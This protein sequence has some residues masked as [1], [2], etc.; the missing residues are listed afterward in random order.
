MKSLII[1]PARK[2]SKRIKNKNLIQILK[3]PLIYWT[4]RYAK[5]LDKKNFDI[6]VTSNCQKIKKICKQEKIFFIDRPKRLSGDLISMHDVIFHTLNTCKKKYKYVILLQ[7]TSP[8]RKSN[9]VNKSIK[10]L[11][12]KDNFDSLIHLA[13]NQSYTGKVIKNKWIPDYSLTKRSQDIKNKF[14]PT[15]NIFVYRS[16]L[17]ENKIKIPKK[18]FGLISANEKWI[19]L[20]TYEDLSLLKLYIKTSGKSQFKIK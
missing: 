9:L 11:D 13:Q 12:K 4:I 5:K 1:I 7:P 2:N 14:T 15:G 18:I 10:I 20:D 3:K 6:V 16:H 8:L 17:Y 19:D